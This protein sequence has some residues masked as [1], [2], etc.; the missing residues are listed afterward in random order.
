MDP[1]T[2]GYFSDLVLFV[3]DSTREVLIFPIGIPPKERRNI[4]EL[5]HGTDLYH[6]SKGVGPDRQVIVLRHRP[7]NISMST[8]P[9]RRALSVQTTQ[10]IQ[11][12][13]PVQTTQVPKVKKHSC[14]S[15]L[16][17]T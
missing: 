7:S 9:V 17:R 3:Q 2:L 15:N 16:T 8:L 12:P 11:P 4:H 13:H 5:A 10:P 1:A 6:R 14:L